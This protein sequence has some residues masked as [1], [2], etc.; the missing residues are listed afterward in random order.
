[1]YF[2]T[3]FEG[4]GLTFNNWLPGY[5]SV[6]L[7][8]MQEEDDDISPII[9]CLETGEDP[10]QATL[11]LSSPNQHIVCNITSRLVPD[12]I[13]FNPLNGFIFCQVTSYSI[14]M[15]M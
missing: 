1:M 14:I 13:L 10:S 2:K 5:S 11:R 12:T 6:E 3:Y 7:R 15:A 4:E 9:Q 8:Q